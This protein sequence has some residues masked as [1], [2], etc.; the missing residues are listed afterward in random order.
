MHNTQSCLII[1]IRQL[2]V[3]I[4]DLNNILHTFEE[5]KCIMLRGISPGVVCEPK[6]G[7]PIPRLAVYAHMVLLFLKGF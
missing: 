1:I 4:E 2:Y 3:V 5:L 7:L 6:L